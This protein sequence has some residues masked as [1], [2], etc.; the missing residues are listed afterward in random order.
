MPTHDPFYIRFYSDRG[1][2]SLLCFLKGAGYQHPLGYSLDPQRLVTLRRKDRE[3]ADQIYLKVKIKDKTVVFA[4]TGG[5]EGYKKWPQDAAYITREVSAYEEPMFVIVD[6]E[7]W[8]IEFEPEGILL[9]CTAIRY[10]FI[11]EILDRAKSKGYL[12]QNDD[13]LPF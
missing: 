10:S 6:N 2:Y 3:G 1:L 7:A 5:P 8:V 12:D 4:R 11:Q 13:E 9:S